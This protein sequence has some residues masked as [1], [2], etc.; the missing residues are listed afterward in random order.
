[1]N[2]KEPQPPNDF[3]ERARALVRVM[4]SNGIDKL[5]DGT[6][7]GQIEDLIH[8]SME[9]TDEIDVIE[10]TVKGKIEARDKINNVI[11]KATK[12]G[13][14]F[15]ESRFGDDA[16]QLEQIGLKRRSKYAP[17]KRKITVQTAAVFAQSSKPKK[18]RMTIIPMPTDDAASTITT[19]T[20]GN[21]VHG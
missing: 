8:A 14:A 1:M 2:L 15:I 13:A 7:A 3:V 9:A 21:G 4:R 16:I 5:P 10:D 11:W 19:H 20:N 6:S 18:S 12:G 17:K